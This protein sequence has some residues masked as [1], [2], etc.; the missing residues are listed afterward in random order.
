MH[1][2]TVV[3]PLFNREETKNQD[4]ALFSKKHSVATVC[5]G[6]SSSPYSAE[7]AELVTQVSPLLFKDNRDYRLSM[8]CD[9]LTLRRDE[10]CKEKE[11]QKVK[12]SESLLGNWMS[13]IVKEQ[14]KS[15]FQT[16]LISASFKKFTK[17]IEVE[18]LRCGDSKFVAL[19]PQGSLL[20]ST[21]EWELNGETRST[22]TQVLPDHFHS[23]LWKHE[24]KIFPK[25]SNIILGSDGFFDAFKSPL[26]LHYWL[27]RHKTGLTQK[28]SNQKIM[29][30]LHK[31]LEQVAHDDDISFIWV[32]NQPFICS[33][34]CRSKLCLST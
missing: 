17:T 3:S 1:A 28:K 24:R 15:A 10:V 8:L 19:S 7:A 20:Y 18:I 29:S 9:L 34:R 26:E 4:R 14:L 23:G 12:S 16:T 25:N 30:N 2:L 22:A 13:E 5:D 31:R 6:V 32:R 21:P 11:N 27:K 33:K